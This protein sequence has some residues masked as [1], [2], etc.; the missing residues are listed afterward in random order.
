MANT[1]RFFAAAAAAAA[2]RPAAEQVLRRDL[3]IAHRLIAHAGMDELIWN[4]ISARIEGGGY[5]VTPG[6][7]H[8]ACMTPNDLVLV[9]GDDEGAG[10][11]ANGGGLENITADVIHGAI[12]RARPDVQ[13]IVHLHSESGM[14]VSALEGGLKY[15]TQDAGA[16]YGKVAWHAFEGVAT[17]HEEQKRIHDDITTK[18]PQGHLPDVLMMRQHGSTCCGE[19]IGEAFVKNFYLERVC[20]V[21]MNLD[22]SAGTGVEVS[23]ELLEKMSEQFRDP[24]LRHGCEWSAMVEYAEAF[25]GCNGDGF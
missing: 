15:Y 2:P 21:Q 19:S 16:F 5:L 11:G 9:G 13:A 14:Y 6:N 8:F 24:T 22:Q 18:T 12:Y 1:R 10:T 17:D 3:A 23:D 20:R 4:H 7:K 25:L